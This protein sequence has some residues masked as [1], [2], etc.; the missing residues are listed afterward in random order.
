MGLIASE[1]PQ[2][3]FL[4]A[5][6][7]S[8]KIRSMISNIIERAYYPEYALTFFLFCLVND[9]EGNCLS[10][11]VRDQHTMLGTGRPLAGFSVPL[12][13]NHMQS[14]RDMAALLFTNEHCVFKNM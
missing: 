4:A 14:S 7:S 2:S 8:V 13:V 1:T 5:D 10:H 6:S 9:F 3:R 12:A 11:R